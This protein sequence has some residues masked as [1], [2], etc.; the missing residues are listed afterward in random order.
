LYNLHALKDLLQWKKEHAAALEEWLNVIGEFEM[1]N[2][3][4]NLST[5]PILFPTLN[6]EFKIDFKNQSSVV[7]C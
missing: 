1:L 6:T 4:A 2:S 5:T 7:K 3:L